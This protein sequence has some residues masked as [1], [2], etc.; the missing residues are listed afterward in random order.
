MC[1]CVLPRLTCRD[2]TSS[3]PMH[4]WHGTAGRAYPS[5]S[6]SRSLLACA[7]LPP[8]LRP[9]SP[10][11]L[12]VR[13]QVSTVARADR[14]RLRAE[15]PLI[16]PRTKQWGWS[17]HSSP[18]ETH[19]AG[20]RG[21]AGG[22]GVADVAS[23][24]GELE[25]PLLA[26][27]AALRRPHATFELGEGELR[28]WSEVHGRARREGRPS[29]ETLRRMRE[30][31]RRAPLPEHDRARE[32]IT[33]TAAA[34]RNGSDPGAENAAGQRG[35]SSLAGAH[36]G[37]GSAAEDAP[38]RAMRSFEH[39]LRRAQLHRHAGGLLEVLS[40][41]EAGRAD[42]W[43]VVETIERLR[44]MRVLPMDLLRLH[45]HEWASVVRGASGGQLGHVAF[46]AVN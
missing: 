17:R 27:A 36:G 32:S 8:S 16:R 28:E 2:V 31:V 4:A 3:V 10:H 23:D 14:E 13:L 1:T 37:M 43:E 20:Q 18:G 5:L 15:V 11:P 6:R 30:L 45:E 41:W 46:D 44:E 29:A 19:S 34:G 26:L 9:P 33:D 7:A 25:P 35:S 38:G 40:A 24:A 39:L 12:L 22:N 21:L 42:V